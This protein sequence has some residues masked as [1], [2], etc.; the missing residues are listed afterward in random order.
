MYCIVKESPIDQKVL[1]RP[2]IRFLTPEQVETLDRSGIKLFSV[3]I[4]N[5]YSKINKLMN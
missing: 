5:I 3:V 2:G 1:E 4:K